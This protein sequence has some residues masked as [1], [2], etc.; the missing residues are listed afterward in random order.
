MQPYIDAIIA[1]VQANQE[2]AAPIAFL[3]AFGESL[4]FVSL[5][6]PSTVI[7]VAIGG[8]L[9]AGGVDLWTVVLAAWVGG[10]LGYAL[11]YWI[12]LY[13][14]DNINAMWPF[15]NHQDMMRRG[16][17][18]F[19]KYGAFGVFFGHFFGPVRA[20]IPVIAGMAAMPQIPFQIANILSAFIWAAGVIA[21]SFYGLKWLTAH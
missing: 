20:V 5:F 15:R 10:S 12:G 13:F 19:E 6:L 11:S 16:E 1:F 21:P 2:W 18:F 4:A 7:L 8:L 14:K 9:G 3:L 17:A